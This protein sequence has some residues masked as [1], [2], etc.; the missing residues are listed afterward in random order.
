[1]N[2]S[3]SIDDGYTHEACLA[4]AKLQFTFRPIPHEMREVIAAAVAR[5]TEAVAAT[6]LLAQTMARHL[7]TWNL[8]EVINADAITQL[9][10]PVFDRLYET[11]AGARPSDPM[12]GTGQ[13]PVRYNEGA[14]L[15]N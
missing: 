4:D 11:I 13:L 7:V 2:H 1:M 14:D 8:L 10:T 12:P 6:H 5:Q 3:F 9:A 15:K